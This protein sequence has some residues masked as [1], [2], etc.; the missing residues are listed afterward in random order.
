MMKDQDV[1]LNQQ[2]SAVLAEE[3]LVHPPERCIKQF[4]LNAER[5]VKFLSHQEK[6]GQFIAK[7]VMPSIGPRGFRVNESM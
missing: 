3:A 1:I 6:E 7:S 5:N 2:I 4:V